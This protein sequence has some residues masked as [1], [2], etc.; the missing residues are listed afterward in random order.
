MMG[1]M[2]NS[3]QSLTVLDWRVDLCSCVEV[4]SPS[5]G[6]RDISAAVFLLRRQN[7]RCQGV[8]WMPMLL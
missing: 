7:D 1:R 6:P 8:S 5:S 4:S 2:A 3:T